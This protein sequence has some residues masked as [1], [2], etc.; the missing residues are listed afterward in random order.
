MM[1]SPAVTMRRVVV[2]QAVVNDGAARANILNCAAE[3]CVS[4]KDPALNH[5]AGIIVLDPSRSSARGIVA[6]GTV[7][8]Y[9]GAAPIHHGLFIS[10]KGAIGKN[11]RAIGERNRGA[12]AV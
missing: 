2:K 12:L 3:S 8:N 7:S 5:R 11:W 1:N 6:E 10:V 9:R 4:G